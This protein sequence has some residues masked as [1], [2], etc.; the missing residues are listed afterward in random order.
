[1]TSCPKVFSLSAQGGSSNYLFGCAEGVADRAASNLTAAYPGLRIAG[2]L[3]GR[4][5]VLG[6]RPGRYDEAD[7]SMM[8][9]AINAARPD[10]LHV[11]AP[12]PMQ[13]D[14]VR[15]LGSL[16]GVAVIITGGSYLDQLAEMVDRYWYHCVL[17][18][19]IGSRGRVRLGGGHVDPFS[20]PRGPT[21]V[22]TTR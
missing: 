3:H 15:R 7:T 14:W 13:Q 19:T 12:T 22:V 17:A 11:C 8:V 10:I 6:G 20:G 4:W 16:L 18:V 5:D 9:S 2:T 1:M 21:S